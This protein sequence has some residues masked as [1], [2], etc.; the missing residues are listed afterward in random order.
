MKHKYPG[1]IRQQKLL[2]RKKLKAKV[3]EQQ[4]R[5]GEKVARLSSID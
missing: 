5:L 1:Y 4:Q 3:E 2:R